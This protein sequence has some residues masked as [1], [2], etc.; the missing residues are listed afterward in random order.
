MVIEY[1]EGNMLGNKVVVIGG[2]VDDEGYEMERV[3]V[4]SG[5]E[6]FGVGDEKWGMGRFVELLVGKV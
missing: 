1:M 4:V 6:G 2:R 5:V 3:E